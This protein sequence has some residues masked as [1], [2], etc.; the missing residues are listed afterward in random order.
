MR[1]KYMASFIILAFLISAISVSAI[2]DYTVGIAPVKDEIFANEDAIF[3]LKITNPTDKVKEFSIYT[4]DVEW[5][6]RTEPAGDYILKVYPHSSS[7][8]IILLTPFAY[9]T[10]GLYG[11]T[12]NVKPLNEEGLDS[13]KLIIEIQEESTPK[14]YLPSVH[15]ET[16][17]LKEIDP[18]KPVKIKVNLVNQNPLEIADL[19]VELSSQLISKSYS[20]TLGPL[21]SKAIDFAINIDQSMHPMLDTLKVSAS[22]KLEDKLFKF[23][24]IQQQYSIIEYG[25]VSEEAIVTKEFLKK[26]KDITLFNEGNIP[27][28]Y[29]VKERYSWTS[30]WLKS[31][32]PEPKIQ[33]E[34]GYKYYVWTLNLEA[35]EKVMV[36]VLTNYWSP[37]IILIMGI[38]IVIT[39]YSFRSPVT[40]KKSSTIE[41]I[42]H[43]GISEMKIQLDVK[44]RGA[45]HVDE[46]ELTDKLTNMLSYYKDEH[47]KCLVPPDKVLKHDKKG[48]ILKWNLGTLEPF[49]ERVITYKVISRLSILGGLSLP[50]TMA[51]Y[52]KG[53]RKIKTTSNRLYLKS[54]V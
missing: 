1:Y 9:K 14:G 31:F 47:L 18:R 33:L 37:V 39:Y 26:T 52:K 48:T 6:M 22:T 16:F 13:K 40:I 3:R 34:E 25:R 43:G 53:R 24:A 10:P 19:R 11:A 21:E 32:N 54:K 23:E 27:L 8:T 5:S 51:S 45:S 7:E 41:S 50:V 36:K 12:I 38:L 20:T 42:K 46:V 30:A 35:K 29:T 15:L 4:P 44:N 28:P 17:M 49:E 2:T